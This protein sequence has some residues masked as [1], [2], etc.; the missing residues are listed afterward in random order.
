MIV[1]N[2]LERMWKEA[3]VA[4]VS[5]YVSWHSPGGTEESRSYAMT[6]READ[7][8]GPFLGNGSVNAFPQQQ[9]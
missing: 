9:T 7:L 6:A 1:N 3:F 5:Y 4:C 2:E 8:P